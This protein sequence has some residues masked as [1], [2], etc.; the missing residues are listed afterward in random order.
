[1]GPTAC[2]TASRSPSWLEKHPEALHGGP[3]RQPVSRARGQHPSELLA[4]CDEKQI[5]VEAYSPIAHG[6]ILDNAD[7]Q[8]M[9]EK[10]DVSVP[11]LCI[12]YTLQLG[13]VPLSGEVAVSGGDRDVWCAPRGRM[14]TVPLITWVRVPSQRSWVSHSVPRTV[15][16]LLW[17]W[18]WNFPWLSLD[19]S[20]R[21]TWAGLG[22]CGRYGLR[23]RPWPRGRG[24]W[25]S[26]RRR[27]GCSSARVGIGVGV[28]VKARV[29]WTLSG[30]RP[31]ASPG[32]R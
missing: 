2:P 7:V 22:A 15:A 20:C 5:L 26:C 24:R 12:R 29:R 21:T 30:W 31:Q 10:Y 18:V 32:R 23:R 3:A 16:T 28:I 27:A 13:T 9:A 17:P 6:A 14:L 25:R 8:A 11:Q 19:Q 1:M 4:Y